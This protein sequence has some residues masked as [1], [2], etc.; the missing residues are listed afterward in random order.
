MNNN[1]P[2]FSIDKKTLFVETHLI[3]LLQFINTII[4]LKHLDDYKLLSI[5]T[6]NL[7]YFH[8]IRYMLC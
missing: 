7:L 1:V 5:Y 2:F 6:I 3:I 8:N 4:L